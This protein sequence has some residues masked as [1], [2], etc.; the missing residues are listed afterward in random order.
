MLLAD[1][2]VIVATVL[3]VASLIPQ[4]GKLWSTKDPTGVSITWPAL[5]LVTNVR[6]TAYLYQQ[7]LWLSVPSAALMVIFYG[8]IL[9]LLARV[10]QRL[11]AGAAR[12]LAW[13][14]TLSAIGV[15]GGWLILGVVLGTSAAIQ[16][17]PAIWTAFRTYAPSG[18]SPGTW[19][20]ILAEAALWG[21]YGKAYADV[22][23]I[24]FAITASAT[25]L[26]MLA[27]FYATRHR[28][29]PVT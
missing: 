8:V 1:V 25:A 10:G 19:W 9:I 11:W 24:I 17:V 21:V 29:A 20:I 28:F 12:G 7:R 6:W 16:V 23:I 27:R 2:S 4:I 22:A 3:A 14:I 18:I 26:L 15:T 13:G 5:G